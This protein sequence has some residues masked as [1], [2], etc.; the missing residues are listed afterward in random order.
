MA[1][2]AKKQQKPK[3]TPQAK[4]IPVP[5]EQATS[6]ATKRGRGRPPKPFK[7]EYIDLAHELMSRGYTRDRLAIELGISIFTLV[8]WERQR[9][10]FAN[11]I[12]AGAEIADSGMELS[13][14]QRGKGYEYEETQIE[15]VLDEE[16]KPIR[17]LKRQ[18]TRHIPGDPRCQMFWLRN[19]QRDR[20]CEG[21][22]GGS[23]VGLFISNM[24]EE[25]RQERARIASLKS[26]Q[27]DGGRA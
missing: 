14:Y 17:R 11:A 23:Q 21:A 5:V 7:Q 19:R 2:K 27:R 3:G 16:G 24:T 20:W 25:Q 6:P 12:R 4:D 18:T 8:Q 22:E 10:E 1:T 26:Q 9:P 13:L 15:A